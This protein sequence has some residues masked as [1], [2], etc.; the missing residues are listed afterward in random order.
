MQNFYGDGNNSYYPEADF[1]AV[2]A[3]SNLYQEFA[4]HPQVAK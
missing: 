1:L 3:Y 2:V 4:F